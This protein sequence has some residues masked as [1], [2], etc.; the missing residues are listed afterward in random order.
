MKIPE[1]A[2][3][4][5]SGKIFDTYQWEQELYDGSF[6]TFEKL[7]RPDTVLVLAMTKDKKLILTKQEQPDEEEFISLLGGRVDKGEDILTAAKREML[8]ES[9]FASD[10]MKLWFVHQPYSKINY[11]VHVFIALDAYKVQEPHLDPG[12]K[13]ELMFV[14]LER[15]IED[16]VYREKYRDPEVALKILRAK[17]NPVELEKIRKLFSA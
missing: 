13:I 9:G 8:E 1:E 12:E 11:E 5:F 14:D 7:D 15:F 6:A 4:V 10:K 2:K 17:N 3:K 16:I